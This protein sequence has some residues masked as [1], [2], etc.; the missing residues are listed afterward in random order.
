MGRASAPRPLPRN[1]LEPKRAEKSGKSPCLLSLP[2]GP[3][4]A[5][6]PHPSSLGE[7]LTGSLGN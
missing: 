6:E 7:P 1:F 2:P 3:T 4:G 5:S